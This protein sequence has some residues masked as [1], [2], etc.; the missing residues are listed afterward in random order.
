MCS[1]AKEVFYGNLDVKDNVSDLA[2]ILSKK[3][4]RKIDKAIKSIESKT[5]A[6]IAVITLDS[7]K[8]N[9]IEKVAKELFDSFGIGKEGQNNG[10]LFLISIADNKYRIEVGQG[11]EELIDEDLE[12]NLKKNLIE[13]YFREGKFGIGI[14]KFINITARKLYSDK[15]SRLA[16][17]AMALGIASISSFAA[18]MVIAAVISLYTYIDLQSNLSILLL[19]VNIFIPAIGFGIGSIIFGSVDI[20]GVQN[21][22]FIET[23]LA[24]SIT[25]IVLGSL[26]LIITVIL[27]YLFAEYIDAV[28]GIFDIASV[29]F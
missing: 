23:K 7:L 26:S 17:A 5:D 21:G 19:F 10:M 15:S 4:V 6:E 14:L 24:K 13:P 27:F 1:H 25:G 12:K 3:Y 22:M 28:A 9:P 20:I 8:G 29:S 18:G 2:A 11:L 16:V